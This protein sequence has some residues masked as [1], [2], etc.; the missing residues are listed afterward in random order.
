MFNYYFNIGIIYFLT[1]FSV[2]LLLYFVFKKRVLGRFWGAL[3]VALIGSYL[4]GLLE[5]VLYDVIEYLRNINNSVNIFP[6]LITSIIIVLLYS[7]LS[8]RA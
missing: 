6:P 8:D 7:K 5:Y 4:G 3:I 2:A 1:G